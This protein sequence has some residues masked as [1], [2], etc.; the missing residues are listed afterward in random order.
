MLLNQFTP[1]EIALIRLTMS[2]FIIREKD[3]LWAIAPNLPKDEI[4]KIENNI[5][6][7]KDVLEKIERNNNLL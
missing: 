2:E 5:S 1:D 4:E 6:L 3:N 7:A